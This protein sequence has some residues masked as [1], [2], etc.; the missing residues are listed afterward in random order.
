MPFKIVHTSI[1]VGAKTHSLMLVL[2]CLNLSD[3]CDTATKPDDR[4]MLQTFIYAA[5]GVSEE[6][7]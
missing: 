7:Q 2:K 5:G 6:Q 1:G 4:L 3:A